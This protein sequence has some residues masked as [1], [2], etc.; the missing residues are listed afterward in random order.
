MRSLYNTPLPKPALCP[1]KTSV[2]PKLSSS[3]VHWAEE[4][5]FFCLFKASKLECEPQTDGRRVEHN[6][7]MPT[8][9]NTGENILTEFPSL[10]LWNEWWYVN[11]TILKCKFS[12]VHKMKIVYI[13]PIPKPTLCPGKTSVLPDLSSSPVHWAEEP[14]LLYLFKSSKLEWD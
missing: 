3:P 2:L 8:T 13:P 12:K 5:R 6:T 9:S 10:F 11:V 1:A 14:R 7:V 4:P